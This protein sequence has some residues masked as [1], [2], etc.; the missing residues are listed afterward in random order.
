MLPVCL[1]HV[2]KLYTHMKLVFYYYCCCCY[3]YYYLAS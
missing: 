2:V 3:Y 1:S